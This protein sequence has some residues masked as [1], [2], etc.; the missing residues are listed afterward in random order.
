MSITKV[1]IR[2]ALTERY[3]PF[4]LIYLVT[5]DDEAVIPKL[6]PYS[7]QF[8]CNDALANEL[9]SM[10]KDVELLALHH[11]RRDE[12]DAVSASDL[13]D[14]ETL[15]GTHVVIPVLPRR[16]QR[17]ATAHQHAIDVAA[18]QLLRGPFTPRAGKE[19]EEKEGEDTSKDEP[20]LEYTTP[21]YIAAKATRNNYALREALNTPAAQRSTWQTALLHRHEARIAVMAALNHRSK[22]NTPKG[23]VQPVCLWCPRHML[24]LQGRCHLGDRVCY[25]ALL[26]R[27]PQEVTPQVTEGPMAPAAVDT[28][29]I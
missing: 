17:K 10:Q 22:F 13:F 21:R 11:E 1:K 19:K 27:D 16:K 9:A 12:L 6:F 24:Q 15:V 29:E 14:P 2:R 23:P 25:D 8:P 18:E 26:L 20:V 5:R 7:L 4:D 3:I 28:M